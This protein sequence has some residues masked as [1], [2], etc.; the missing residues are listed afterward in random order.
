MTFVGDV[1]LTAAAA[2]VLVSLVIVYRLV[3]GPTMQD[4]VIAVNVIGSNIVITIALVAGALGDPAALDIAIVYA[5]LN[6]LMSI[7]ISKF[8][9]ERGGVL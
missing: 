3:R 6:F 2:F 7:A 1:L 9:V 8:T 4:R 5:L